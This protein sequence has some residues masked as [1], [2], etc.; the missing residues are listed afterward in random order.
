[1]K[2]VNDKY[3]DYADLKRRADAAMTDQ[4]KA[5]V[6]AEARGK[7]AA[8]TASGQ[9][10]ARAEFKAAALDRVEKASLDGFL[11]FADMTKFL[12]ADGEPD[13]KAIEA[14][15][16][17]LAGP[18]KAPDF[19]GGARTGATKPIDMNALIRSKAGLG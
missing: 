9:R 19:D 17:K 8:L 14:A 15:I 13:P 6:E 16:T 3:A 11:E 12:G 2:R 4:E 1:V 7:A 18:N 10:L 5:V